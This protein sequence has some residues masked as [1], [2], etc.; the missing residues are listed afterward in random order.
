MDCPAGKIPERLLMPVGVD[1]KPH[2]AL[3]KPWG[4]AVYERQEAGGALV[5]A[6]TGSFEPGSQYVVSLARPAHSA[7]EGTSHSKSEVSDKRSVRLEQLAQRIYS[8]LDRRAVVKHEDRILG[9]N[10][11]LHRQIDVSIRADVAGHAVLVIVDTKDYSDPADINDVEQFSATLAD[12]RASKGVMICNAGFTKGAHQLAK[13]SGID[14]CSVFEA[15]H[16]DW[17]EDL[18]IP[19]LMDNTGVIVRQR[20]L[21]A[22]PKGFSVPTDSAQW[23]F[24][25]SGQSLKPTEQFARAWNENRVAKDIGEWHSFPLP[26][27]GLC[28]Q[29]TRETEQAREE[30]WT[31]IVEYAFDYWVKRE[32]YFKFCEPGEYRGLKNLS[33][34]KLQISALQVAVPKEIDLE[35]WERIADDDALHERA[36]DWVLTIQQL[37]SGNTEGGEVVLRSPDTVKDE[38]F[39]P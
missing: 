4:F 22:L 34:D 21:I 2:E 16:R 37:L 25:V 13:R 3:S 6:F 28:V 23:R 8:E 30:R 10:S 38:G 7:S 12:V 31:P 29:A 11:N 15:G 39:E 36:G 17:G 19:V 18:K 32:W 5:Y 20:G 33:A 24:A 1:R 27:T 26:V 35:E 14:L 9:L